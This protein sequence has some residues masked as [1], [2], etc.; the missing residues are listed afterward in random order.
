MQ[1]FWC[2]LLLFSRLLHIS[3]T[4]YITHDSPF[5]M[6]IL[7]WSRINARIF[8]ATVVVA[9]SPF[10]LKIQFPFKPLIVAKNL[11]EGLTSALSSRISNIL[12]FL[13][14]YQIDSSDNLVESEAVYLANIGRVFGSSGS[15]E[16][17]GGDGRWAFLDQ[18]PEAG[19][20]MS[21]SRIG[22]LAFPPGRQVELLGSPAGRKG[23]DVSHHGGSWFNQ[24]Q[25]YRCVLP[26]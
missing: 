6:L 24:T 12:V 25:C 2:L 10:P 4:V 26:G 18:L 15:L 14:N 19:G 23:A 1:V 13:P 3:I 22:R 20:V 17:A 11:A 21:G 8:Q 7:R 5:F 16:Q 9:N